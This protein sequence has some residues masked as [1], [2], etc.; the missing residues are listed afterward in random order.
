M[1][2]KCIVVPDFEAE[3]TDRMLYIKP[4]YTTED[5]VRTVTINHTDGAGM[6]LPNATIIPEALRR[7]NFMF[8]SNYHK[9]LLSPFDYIEFCKVNNVPPVIKDFWG[10]EHNLVE[11]DIQII[12]CVSQFKLAKLYSSHKEFKE[13]YKRYGCQFSIAQYEEDWPPDKTYNYQMTQTMTDFTDEEIKEYTEK[14][15]QKILDLAKDKTAML[16][17]LK[18]KEDA[19]TKDKVALAIYPEFLR[20]GYSRQQL[21]DTK[22]R[23]LLDAKSGAIKCKNKRLYVVPDFYAA[24]ERWFLGIDRPR[25]LLEKDEIACLPYIKYEKADVLRS[26][27][28]YC[29]HF[30]ARICKDP[31]VYKWFITDGIVTSV[32]SLVSRILQFDCDG[33]M[34]N[35]VVEPVIVKVAERNLKEFDVI[36]LFYDA[37][38]APAEQLSKRTLFEGLKRAHQFSNIGEI[39]NMLTRLWNRDKPDRHVAALLTM[40]NNARID[41]AKNGKCN[42]YTNYP[43]IEKRVNKATG[44]P[45]GRMPF[46]FSASRNGRRDKTTNR[47]HKRQWAKPNNSTMNRIC[48]AFDDIGNI[49]MNWAGV[50][51]FNWQML[52]SEPC[53][54]TRTDIIAEFCDLDNIKVSLAISNAEDSPAEKDIINNNAIIDEHITDTLIR[55]FGSLETCYPYIVKHLFTGEGFAKQSHKQTFWR[56]FGDIAVE[57]LSRNLENCRTCPD[58]GA[59]IPNWVKTHT[60]LKSGQG[61]YACIDCGK[62]CQRTNSR[63]ERCPDCQEHHRHDMK[64]LSRKRTQ[65]EREEREKSFTTLWRYRFKKM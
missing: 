9:G 56:I 27:H 44:G 64:E 26:P 65:E 47:K 14:T 46:W 24:C 58:C 32:N 12:F 29:E 45:N 31:K 54:Y 60:C 53:L 7:K 40:L 63:Q 35:V 10:L 42:E 30:I 59:K 22:K 28:L 18:A 11:E 51:P 17:T 4:D 8:R 19:F 61:F 25:G 37:N 50:P 1:I 43:E 36:P 49:N 39:S 41:G 38:K 6:I 13:A 23:M 48:K 33:D 3:V 5:G 62:L 20:D 21:K 57:N 16:E 52:L 15:H 2:E 55:K 34:L